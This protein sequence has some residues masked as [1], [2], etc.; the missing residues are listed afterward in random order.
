MEIITPE[1]QDDVRRALAVNDRSPLEK[2]G[3]FLEPVATR[4]GAH[5]ALLDSVYATYSDRT[6]NCKN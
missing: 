3:R 1:T 6:T 2:Y 4:I 5:S